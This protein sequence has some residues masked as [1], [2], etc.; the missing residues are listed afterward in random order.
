MALSTAPIGST[1]TEHF[2]LPKR[3]A[4]MRKA[5]AL[6]QATGRDIIHLEKGEEFLP[7]PVHSR[8]LCVRVAGR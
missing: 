5:E 7:A 8:G 4:S 2:A 1:R 6:E 3:W